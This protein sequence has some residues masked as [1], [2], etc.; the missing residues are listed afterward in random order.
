VLE[1]SDWTENAGKW[2]TCLLPRTSY[3]DRTGDVKPTRFSPRQS[4]ACGLV[5]TAVLQ[6][7]L[8]YSVGTSPTPLR[9]LSD[10]VWHVGRGRG[11][12]ERRRRARRITRRASPR[13]RVVGGGA[14]PPGSTQY[15]L[16][17]MPNAKKP[18]N[19]NSWAPT[20]LRHRL[21]RRPKDARRRAMERG[22]RARRI[23]RRASPRRRGG[24]LPPGK[25]HSAVWQN[26]QK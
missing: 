7:K 8:F 17:K 14:L 22:R 12:M 1:R 20:L 4:S 10:T 16:A 2:R 5:G 3:E 24:A 13:P 23:T 9:H 19:N 11:A 26:N 25:R 18:K 6:P 21:A 15:R